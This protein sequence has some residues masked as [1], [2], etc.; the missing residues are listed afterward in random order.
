MLWIKPLYFPSFCS[1][2]KMCALHVLYSDWNSEIHATDLRQFYHQHHT[3]F[4]HF[5]LFFFALSYLTWPLPDFCRYLWILLVQQTSMRTNSR[6][7]SRVLRW[8]WGRRLTP[9]SPSSV[10]PVSVR[11][12]VTTTHLISFSYNSYFWLLPFI[13]SILLNLQGAGK[14]PWVFIVRR[15]SCGENSEA[16]VL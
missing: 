10:Q 5:L 9:S 11:R 7:C 8:L 12:L 15:W 6:S 3:T 16:S 2:C 4:C 1:P 13:C 14:F